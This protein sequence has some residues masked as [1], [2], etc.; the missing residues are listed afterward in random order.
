MDTLFTMTEWIPVVNLPALEKE[1]KR[2]NKKADKNFCPKIEYRKTGETR[3]QSH[4]LQDYAA[5]EVIFV[6]RVPVQDDWRFV[7][8]LERISLDDGTEQNVVRE[9]PGL[10]CPAHLRHQVGS[11]DHCAINRFRKQTYV[12]QHEKSRE[13]KCVGRSCLQDFMGKKDLNKVIQHFSDVCDLVSITHRLC[14]YGLNYGWDL[15]HFMEYVACS[16]RLD[17]WMSGSKS[18]LSGLD[19]TSHRVQ[20]LLTQ[21][22]NDPSIRQSWLDA[23]TRHKITDADRELAAE[24]IEWIVDAEEK[25]LID[26]TYL[27]NIHLIARHGTVD[28][29]NA[30]YAASIIAAYQIQR[31]KKLAEQRKPRVVA[32]GG[33]YGTVGNKFEDLEV[34]CESSFQYQP[35]KY[36]INFLTKGLH[37]LTWFTYNPLTPGNYCIDGK[38]KRH[39]AYQQQAQ[40]L[41]SVSE[42]KPPK[43]AESSSVK[44]KGKKTKS[45]KP[46]KQ[47]KSHV[48]RS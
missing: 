42:V 2:L 12:I 26:S 28:S 11:C 22:P 39:G 13:F 4:G 14:N 31:D 8:S 35:G 17:G 6:G 44:K 7:A 45:P 9:V 5:V 1:L 33:L 40:T 47:E 37:R 23:L 10:S 48:A 43:P 36:V 21:P 20:Y 25:T 34:E 30:G 19:S 15:G 41:V 29:R 38:I 32:T 18:R 27:T 46:K 16:I 24:A 3:K